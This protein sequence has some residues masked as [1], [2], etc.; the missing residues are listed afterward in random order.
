MQRPLG[1]HPQQQP[2][3]QPSAVAYPH[4]DEYAQILASNEV[5]FPLYSSNLLNQQQA[6]QFQG[7]HSSSSSSSMFGSSGYSDNSLLQQ[8]QQQQQQQFGYYP[9][10]YGGS[11]G[12]SDFPGHGNDFSG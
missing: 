6:G 10:W 12:P 8:Q 7:S 2:P 3:Q 4:L 5:E 9:Q 1:P 11:S